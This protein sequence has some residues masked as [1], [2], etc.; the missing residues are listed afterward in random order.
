MLMARYLMK[1]DIVDG[2]F[3]AIFIMHII[4][5]IPTTDFYSVRQAPESYRY[6]NIKMHLFSIYFLSF[7]VSLYCTD[8]REV[9]LI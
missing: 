4:C 6:L 2:M 5:D 9:Y 1:I 3:K 8:G 7:K